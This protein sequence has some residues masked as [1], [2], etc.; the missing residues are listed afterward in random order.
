MKLYLATSN[1]GKTAELRR[2]LAEAEVPVEVMT[3]DEAGGMPAVAETESTF[4]G[5]A[6]LK[7]RALKSVVPPEAWVLADDSG[8]EVPALGREPGVH[9]ARYAGENAT[10]AD[11][12]HL[13]SQRMEGIPRE[14]RG[15]RFVCVLLLLDPSGREHVFE[16]SCRGRIGLKPKGSGGFGYDP[17]FVPE[18]HERTF[19]ELPP[20]TKNRLSHRGEALR[21][22][23]S[24][25]RENIPSNASGKNQV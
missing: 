18:G 6:R 15:G 9:S 11:N 12:R 17:L 20:E 10:D 22:L 8:L 1:P 7:A 4:A 23:V 16:G 3:A 2:M 24:W 14:E 5:N 19:G 21:Q 13:L 25:L